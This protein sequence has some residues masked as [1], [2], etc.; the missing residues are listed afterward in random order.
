LSPLGALLPDI[1]K[2]QI[3]HR[4]KYPLDPRM[5]PMG[6]RFELVGRRADGTT[7]PV[8]VM[9]N[10]LKH[11]AEPTALAV[12]RD[13]TDRRAAEAALRQ[14][15]AMFETFYERS[16]DAII[17]VDQTGKI[18]RVNGPAEAMFGLLRERMLGQAI[19]LLIPERFR[20]RHLAHRVNYMKAPKTRAMGTDLQL[21]AQRADGGEFPVDIMLSPIE[22]DQRPLVLT[23]VRDITERK[24]AEAQVQQLLREVKHR[25][26]NILSVV[27]AIAHQ[28]TANSV[29]EFVLQFSERIRGLSSSLDLLVKNEWKSVSLA[30]LVGSQ[31]AHFGILLEGR[32]AVRG[33]DLR[34]TAAA[35]QTIGMALHE[36][37]TNASKYGALSTGSGRAD[38]VWGFEDTKAGAHRFT[39]EWSER[40]GPTVVAPTRW[41]FGSSVLCQLT[42]MSLG[43]DVTLEY[44]PTGVVWR[45]VC[46]VE[47]VCETGAAQT[48][49]VT[50]PTEPM[51]KRDRPARR[52]RPYRVGDR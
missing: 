35:A 32:V 43:A 33:P 31:L 8:D 2:R 37:I 6:T 14:S 7:F 52:A 45:L 38:I 36:L 46:P 9:L 1:R 4:G 24:R 34:I 23:V 42:K 27:Q 3:G 29:Q 48:K 41:G 15:R 28:T 26:K 25:A 16:P 20:Q 18:S 50:S 13:I 10:P 49:T 30:E 19:E 39:I 40:G 17:V 5:W 12:I 22:I 44:A 21:F 11:L 47:R 51:S